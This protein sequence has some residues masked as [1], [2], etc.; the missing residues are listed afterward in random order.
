MPTTARRFLDVVNAYSRFKTA[1]ETPDEALG[2]LD[3]EQLKT[4][5]LVSAELFKKI[6][7]EA[8]RRGVWDELKGVKVP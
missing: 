1:T 4:A 5:L 2:T 8:Q 3:D 7:I 6:K